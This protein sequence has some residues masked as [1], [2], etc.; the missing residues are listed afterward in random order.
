MDADRVTDPDAVWVPCPDCDEYWC[1]RHAMHACDCDCPPLEDWIGTGVDP[2]L[3]VL[4][5]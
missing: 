2:Y 3:G 1:R 5:D 4:D